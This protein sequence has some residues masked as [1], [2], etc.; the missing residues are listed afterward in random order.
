MKNRIRTVVEQDEECGD[1]KSE[2][3]D[4]ECEEQDE[5]YGRIG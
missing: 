5:E 4:E 1:E 3:Q 2:E